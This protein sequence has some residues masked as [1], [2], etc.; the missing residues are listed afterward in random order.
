MRERAQELGG[1]FTLRSSGQG[2]RVE[3]A[4]PVVLT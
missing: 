3:A 1:T 2:A 4:L